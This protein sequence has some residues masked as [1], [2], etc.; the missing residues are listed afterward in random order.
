M[1]RAALIFILLLGCAR[2]PGPMLTRAV[3]HDQAHRAPN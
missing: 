3:I 2:D 1:I